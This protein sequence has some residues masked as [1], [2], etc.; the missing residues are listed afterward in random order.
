[1]SKAGITAGPFISWRPNGQQH[2]TATD[3]VAASVARSGSSFYWAMKVLPRDRRAAMFAIYAFCRAV[4]DVADQPGET[5]EKRAALAEWRREIERV[6][7]GAPLT[8]IGRELLTAVRRFDL[9]CADFV[10]VVDGMEMD[11]DDAMRGPSMTELDLYCSRVAGAVGRLSI[12]AFGMPP[13]VGRRVAELLGRAFQLTNILRDLVEDAAIGRLY[14]PRE[15]LVA[16]DIHMRDPTSVLRHPALPRVCDAVAALA[17]RDF[18]QAAEAMAKCP[19]AA[20]RP[21]RVMMEIYRRLLHRLVAR[22]WTQLDEPVAVP[23]A[24]KLLIAARYG[25]L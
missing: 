9:Q 21:A 24:T 3:S 16:H 15:L 1:M 5:E 8:A 23:K 17:E 22:G 18:E 4:D 6:Y 7:A 20:A 2:V 25:L 13:E 19:R 11:V 12:R 14:L 10:A